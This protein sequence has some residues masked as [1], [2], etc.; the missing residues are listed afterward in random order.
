MSSR[1]PLTG[2]VLSPW[3]DLLRRWAQ[4]G[5]L[6]QAARGALRLEGEQ[7]LLAALLQDW[8]GGRFSRL[9]SVHVLDHGLPAEAL[10][11][12][13]EGAILLQASWLQGA[14]GAQLEAVL[15]EELGHHLDALLNNSDTAGDEGELLVPAPQALLTAL[16]PGSVDTETPAVLLELAANTA[17]TAVRLS[18][19][20]L[21]EGE[22]PGAVVGSLSSVDA[23]TADTFT[24]TLVSGSGSDDNGAFSIN[25]Y[26]Q[27]VTRT[28]LDWEQKTSYRVRIRSTDAGGRQ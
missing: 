25:Q 10:G 22:A 5:Q 26:N 18:T 19:S 7:P 15:T 9:P 2:A 27:L 3:L 16:A 4:D 11:A 12:Y 24:Y 13:G 1:L 21:N 20:T 14:S 6:E 8:A 28:S 17:P 23:D